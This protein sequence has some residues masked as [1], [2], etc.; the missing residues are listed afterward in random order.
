MHDDSWLRH[1][2][3]PRPPAVPH[4]GPELRALIELDSS[5]FGTGAVPASNPTQGEATTSGNT[6]PKKPKASRPRARPR[7]TRTGT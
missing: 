5:D 6:R 1:P 4:F 3:L 7:A 2:V